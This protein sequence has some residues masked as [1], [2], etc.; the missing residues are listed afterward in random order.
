MSQAIEQAPP[1]GEPPTLRQHCARILTE[2]EG[3]YAQSPRKSLLRSIE[4][5]KSLMAR[6]PKDKQPSTPK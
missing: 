1:C 5:V 4:E 2:L 3:L 6:L